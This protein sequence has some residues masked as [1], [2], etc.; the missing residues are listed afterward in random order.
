[1]KEWICVNGKRLPKSA[2]TAY[3]DIGDGWLKVRERGKFTLYRIGEENMDRML[4]YL[5]MTYPDF[6][7]LG[8]WRVA[9]G[10]VKSYQARGLTSDDK[11]TIA[12]NLSFQAE[13]STSV[14]TANEQDYK[15]LLNSFDKLF[16]VI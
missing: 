2:I 11:F 12:F 14:K 16:N 15:D 9:K 7:L 4:A 6:V 8:T 13:G 3:T 5:A 1:M 10:Q